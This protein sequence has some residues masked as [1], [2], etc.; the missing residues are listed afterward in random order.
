VAT[1]PEPAS[2]P[3]NEAQDTYIENRDPTEMAMCFILAAAYLGLA[4]YCWTPLW[5]A[6]NLKLFINVEGFF[7]T[8]ALISIL[9]GLRPYI[10]PSS[11]Q[12]S[13]RGIKYRGPYWPQRRSVTW[14]Q[15]IKV[16]LSSEL[17]FILY[18]PKLDSKRMW[19][20]LI[21]SVYLASREKIAASM[22]NYCTKPLEIVTNPALYSRILIGLLFFI[23][24]IWI[25][26]M[27]MN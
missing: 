2:N 19:A 14:D 8:I 17:I 10:S 4:R 18:K 3:E 25:L 11:M 15:V 21:A 27:L 20:M 26:E 16:Y 12:I 22:E 13:H 9:V 24:V 5:A 6:K 7:I 23:A 1:K